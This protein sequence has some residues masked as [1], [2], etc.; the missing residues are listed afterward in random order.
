MRI[1]RMALLVIADILGLKVVV[2]CESGKEEDLG[3][4]FKTKLWMVTRQF[5]RFCQIGLGK[6]SETLKGYRKGQLL[7]L[8]ALP[9]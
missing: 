2:T 7:V 1:L 4:E 3:W 9:G 8:A 6:E 5:V